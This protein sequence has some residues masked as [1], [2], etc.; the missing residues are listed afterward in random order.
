[1]KVY[2]ATSGYYDEYTVRRVFRNKKDAEDYELAD[3]VEEFEVC[4]GPA[5]VRTLYL[6]Y[7]DKRSGDTW[8]RSTREDI[9]NPDQEFVPE[10]CVGILRSAYG[11][12]VR[13]WDEDAVQ[14]VFVSE[15]A[16]YLPGKTYSKEEQIVPIRTPFDEEKP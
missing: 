9:S 5:E 3:D 15:R 1:M 10:G 14:R 11:L 4:E 13:G 7:W 8:S 6:S 2:L 12:R 16:A